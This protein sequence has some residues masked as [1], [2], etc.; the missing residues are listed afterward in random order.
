LTLPLA[1]AAVGVVLISI[2]AAAQ[3]KTGDAPRTTTTSTTGATA[4]QR[5]RSAAT[6]RS[7]P[8]PPGR[9]YSFD[10]WDW[11]APCRDLHTFKQWAADLKRIGVTRLG[12]SAPWNVL[13]PEPGQYQLGFVADRV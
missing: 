3:G 13:E 10:L 5:A 7:L 9:E 11:T 12:F 8:P 6:T 4:Q 1:I 2:S